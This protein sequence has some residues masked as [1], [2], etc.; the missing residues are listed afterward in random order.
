MAFS[1][2]AVPFSPVQIVHP[3]AVQ[4][5]PERCV[6]NLTLR[7]CSFQDTDRV[8]PKMLSP[9]CLCKAEIEFASAVLAFVGFF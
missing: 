2:K 7:C 3:A 4:C 5:F 8:V 6:Y 1:L 9:E